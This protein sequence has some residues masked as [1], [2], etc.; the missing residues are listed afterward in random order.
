[1]QNDDMDLLEVYRAVSGDG[2]ADFENGKKAM[3]AAAKGWKVF[4]KSPKC[5]NKKGGVPFASLMVEEYQNEDGGVSHH[6]TIEVNG[7][8]SL[9]ISN[10]DCPEIHG[11]RVAD[12]IELVAAG[13]VI[14]KFFC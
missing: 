11:V 5:C 3:K 1:M 7:K 14:V 9:G 2:S 8:D 4:A 13:R 12:G 10:A 6:L